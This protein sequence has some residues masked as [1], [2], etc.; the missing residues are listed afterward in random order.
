MKD[1]EVKGDDGVA[2]YC[3][4]SVKGG[5]GCACVVSG[6]V[7][8]VGITCGDGLNGGGRMPDGEMQGVH[9]VTTI[10]ISM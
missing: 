7:P 2:A 4:Q 5:R 3:V 1:S 10:V 6:A 9:L 8:D